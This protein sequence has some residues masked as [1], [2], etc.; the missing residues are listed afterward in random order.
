MSTGE[1]TRT[2]DGDADGELADQL[3]EHAVVMCRV[4]MAL[5]ADAAR[6]ERVLEHVARE[7]STRARPEGARPLAWLLGLVRSTCAVHLSKLPLRTRSGL[8]A[9]DD[10]AP[11]TERLG[12]AAAVPARAALATLR[13]TEREAVVLF[14]VGGLDANDVA[15]ACNV[16]LATARARLARGL[17][18]LLANAPGEVGGAR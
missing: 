11:G 4:A 10:A 6:V 12:A 7:A 16:E 3:R 9:E 17:E 14:L 18:E 13:P 15:I 8:P 5:L 1:G 2:H